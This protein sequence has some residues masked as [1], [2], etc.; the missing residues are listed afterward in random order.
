MCTCAQLATAKNRNLIWKRDAS[1]L[2]YLYVFP[3]LSKKQATAGK[4][5][6]NIPTN[7]EHLCTA[8]HRYVQKNTN[9][10]CERNAPAIYPYSQTG[11]RVQNKI[12]KTLTFL[13]NI[14]QPMP[15]DHFIISY[16]DFLV[17]YLN[18]GPWPVT[19]CIH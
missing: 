2:F 8:D 19:V 13:F 6:V 3:P 18:Y 11:A 14:N 17:R 4:T 5:P 15:D 12:K 16:F 7:N 1:I 9:L 10:I